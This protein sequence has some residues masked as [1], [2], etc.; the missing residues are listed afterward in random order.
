M[1]PKLAKNLKP[2]KIV[3]DKDFFYRLG[4][5]GLWVMRQ[6]KIDVIEKPFGAEKF[7]KFKHNE[8]DKRFRKWLPGE[9]KEQRKLFNEPPT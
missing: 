1:K 4:K 2:G 3:S 6:A 8:Y 5:T 7:E 9:H